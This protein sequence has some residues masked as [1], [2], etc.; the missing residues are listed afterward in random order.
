MNRQLYFVV[1]DSGLNA[2]D[3]IFVQRLEDIR[4]R[5]MRR[6]IRGGWTL[7]ISI[8]GSQEF[9]A[10]QVRAIRGGQ[11]S[12]DADAVR[13]IFGQ[14]QAFVRWRDEHGPRRV[15]LNACQV[16]ANLE[17]AIIQSLTRSGSGQVVQGL[18]TGCRPSTYVQTYEYDGRAIRTMGQYQR[19]PAEARTQMLEILRWLNQRWGYF[20]APPVPE[21]AILDYYFTEEPR[22]G[23]PIVRVSHDRRDTDIPFY[24]RASDPEFRRLCTSGVGTLREHVPSMPPAAPTPRQ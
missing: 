9:I 20:G 16:S 1:G 22:G 18:G 6:R 19:L 15:V 14:N 24:N 4:P 12:Y 5:L 7:V 21:T 3:G 8:H 10:N 17:R 11:G 23:W 13:R 2:G